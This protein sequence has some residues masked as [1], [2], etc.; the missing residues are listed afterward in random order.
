[1]QFV[2]A[3]DVLGLLGDLA[4]LG[5]QQFGTDGRGQ[6]RGEHLGKAGSGLALSEAL[7]VIGAILHQVTHQGLGH[8][9]IDRVH[10]HVV[11][12][13]GGPS[14]GQFGQVARTDDQTLGLIGQVHEQLGT[15]AGLD[16]FEGYVVT[17]RV[18]VD[19]TEVLI[20]GRLDVDGL[21]GYAQEFGQGQGIALGAI[22]GAGA[23]HGYGLE[24]LSGPA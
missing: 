5:R 8:R 22:R 9:G 19:V 16:V 13:V 20:H 12:V 24:S 23:G 17:G 15:F 1:M 7:R 2:G 6:D 3:H 21:G 11:A 14:Q 4:V 18:V 10:A